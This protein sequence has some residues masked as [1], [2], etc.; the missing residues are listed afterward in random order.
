MFCLLLLMDPKKNTL[1]YLN[2]HAVSI[3]KM[4]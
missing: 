3:V 2:C 4:A 1:I